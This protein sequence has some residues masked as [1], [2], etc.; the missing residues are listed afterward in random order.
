MFK[1]S[2]LV[3]LVMALFFAVAAVAVTPEP[4]LA[5]V[6]QQNAALEGVNIYFTEA[7]AEASRF[8]RSENGLSRFAGLLTQQ[9]ANLFTL[10]WRTGFPTDAD[11]IVIAGP[12]TDLTADQ[13][14][15]L[16]SY[17]NNGGRMLL[18]ANTVIESRRALGAAGGLFSLMYADMGLRGLDN[19]VLDAAILTPDEET[20]RPEG[21]AARIAQGV[22][23]ATGINPTHPITSDLQ[24]ELYF[25]LARSLDV[26]SAIQGFTVTPL[27]TTSNAYYGEMNF[28][29]Y[30]G[31]ADIAYNIGVDQTQGVF[32]LAAAYENPGTG[33]RIVVVGDREFATNGRGLLTAPPN[34]AG[35]VYPEN[36]RFLLN[37][38]AWLLEGE[39]VEVDF[40]TP[41]PTSTVTLTP[42]F[43][44]TPSPTPAVTATPPPTPTPAS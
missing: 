26:D 39:P 40:P 8:D 31:G 22:F 36:A 1:R 37:A 43:T 20:P 6:Q 4:A 25:N 34:S 2:V 17:V 21:A 15:R 10:E 41:G 7:G 3:L 5:E 14:A 11:L 42:T 30:V 32:P 9:G 28:A 29:D 12:V 27:I 18:L 38:A 44:P 19:V 16:W 24:G 33:S 23:V 13:V 35:F